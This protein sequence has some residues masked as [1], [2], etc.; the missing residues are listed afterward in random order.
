MLWLEPTRNVDVIGTQEPLNV[1]NASR[2]CSLVNRASDSPL[3]QTDAATT[4][5]R[6]PPLVT[7]SASHWL[8]HL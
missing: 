4:E 6:V 7:T 8:K 3:T 2:N 1:T 5:L